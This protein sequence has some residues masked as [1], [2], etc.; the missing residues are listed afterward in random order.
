MIR[1]E[2]SPEEASS[3]E[4][5]VS[6]DIPSSDPPAESIDDRTFRHFVTS[7]DGLAFERI[8]RRHERLVMG[9]CVRILGQ[10]QAAEDAFQETFLALAKRAATIRD[11]GS[12]PGWLHRVA[13]NEALR[14]RLQAQRRVAR[15]AAAGEKELVVPGPAPEDRQIFA[16]IDEALGQLPD[17]YRQPLVLRYLE[18]LSTDTAARKLGRPKGS[19]STLI[20]RGLELLRSGLHEKGVAVTGGALL[21][22][23]GAL[24]AQGQ[25]VAPA[26]VASVV[27]LSVPAAGLTLAATVKTVL[28][29]VL[30]A[31]AGSGVL[32]PSLPSTPPA[33]ELVLPVEYIAAGPPAPDPA[34]LRVELPVVRSAAPV[35]EPPPRKETRN[36]TAG[37]PDVLPE[38]PDLPETAS[39]KA[40]AALLRVLERRNDREPKDPKPTKLTGLDRAEEAGRGVKSASDRAHEAVRQTRGRS[41]K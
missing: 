39:E 28:T 23:L 25:A 15:E 37:A 4:E 1:K 26:L 29:A 38:L 11:P 27:R 3:D 16:L 30:V 12:L 35:F 8:V 36:E 22:A 6:L 5:A 7:G 21:S 13:S 32:L 24:A 18:G 40:E 9:V 17:K 31:A 2:Y 20:A 19:M 10:R 34:E 33:T 41:G 14:I